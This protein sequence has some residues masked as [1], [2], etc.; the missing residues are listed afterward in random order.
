M[1]LA[2]G[3]LGLT[4]TNTYSGVTTVD[5]G[6]TLQLG[7]AG[8][9]G[10]VAGAVVD[11][12]LVQFDYCGPVTT[13]NAF[14]GTGSAE[15]V[16]GTVVVTGGS[17]ARRRGHDRQRRHPAVGRWRARPSWSAAATRWSTTARW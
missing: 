16:A 14:S 13:P 12:G 4:G 10:T 6:A 3:T 5:T 11:N 9:T 2:N 8:R 17:V 15:V 1:T 7:E